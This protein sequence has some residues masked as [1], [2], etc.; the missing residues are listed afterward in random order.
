MD[1]NTVLIIEDDVEVSQ[2]VGSSIERLG[3][4][5]QYVEDGESGLRLAIDGEYRLVIL[6]LG[7]P[8]LDGLEVCKRLRAK[9]RTLPLIILSAR[10]DEL[11]IVLGLQFGADDYVT[12][13]FSI[14]ELLARIDAVLRRSV[15]SVEPAGPVEDTKQA[16]VIGELEIDLNRCVVKCR[17]KVSHL[18][19]LEF[20]LLTYLAMP[21][22]R[23]RTREELIHEVLGYT[24]NGYQYSIASHISRMRAKLETDPNQP[25]YLLTVRGVGY[26]LVANN[27]LNC[28]DHYVI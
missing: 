19:P 26:R 16:I 27:E 22:G 3:L 24:S 23:V 17:G 4:R 1:S 14:R 11:D 21:A 10:G 6:D 12:K 18:T 7:L 15:R 2:L 5:P 28:T 9:K 25:E 8:R 20:Q 13:P